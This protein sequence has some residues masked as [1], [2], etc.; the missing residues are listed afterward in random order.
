MEISF[1]LIQILMK[2]SQPNNAH[3]MTML[4][5]HMQNCVAIWYPAIELQLSEISIEFEL[6]WKNSERNDSLH[7]DQRHLY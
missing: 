7:H 5:W 6:W 1:T 3:G 4:S 2:W